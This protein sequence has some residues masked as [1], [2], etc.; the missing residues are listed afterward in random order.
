[1]QRQWPSHAHPQYTETAT[2]LN[3]GNKT[4]VYIYKWGYNRQAGERQR[5]NAYTHTHIEMR[6]GDSIGSTRAFHEAEAASRKPA[7]SNYRER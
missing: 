5:S 3:N 4:N 7:Q 1:M 2:D 6:D